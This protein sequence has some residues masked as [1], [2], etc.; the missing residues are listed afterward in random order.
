M[1]D[2]LDS[3]ERRPGPSDF[4]AEKRFAGYNEK[5]TEF[6]QNLPLALEKSLYGGSRTDTLKVSGQATHTLNLNTGTGALNRY[7]YGYRFTPLLQ[8]QDTHGTHLG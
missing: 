1:C 6:L 5:S 4:N 3:G 7:R 2:V 8:T